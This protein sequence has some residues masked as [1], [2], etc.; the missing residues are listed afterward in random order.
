MSL[1]MQGLIK[2][3]KSCNELFKEFA[4]YIWDEKAAEHG[5]DKPIKEHDHC[6][7]ALRYYCNTII[8]NRPKQ[9]SMTRR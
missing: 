4:S 3:D 8:G 5:E 7:D 2:F 6:C 9:V 1:M